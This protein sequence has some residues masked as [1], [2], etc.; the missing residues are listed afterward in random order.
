LIMAR[1]RKSSKAD[2]ILGGLL[3]LA[4]VIG[5]I[6][7][8]VKE[9]SQEIISIAVAIGLIWIVIHFIGRKRKSDT[10]S[11]EYSS[12]AAMPKVQRV[13]SGSPPSRRPS[14]WSQSRLDSDG[15]KEPSI[16]ITALVDPPRSLAAKPGAVLRD[17]RWIRRGETVTI[18]EIT[19]TSGLFY[20]GTNLPTNFYRTEYCLI[21]PGLPIS[22]SS[23]RAAEVGIDSGYTEF[24]PSQRRAF[25][26]WMS[27]GR[28]DPNA[29]PS[30]VSLFLFGL[31]Y[32]LFKQGAVSDAPELIR[33]I[34]RLIEVYGGHSQFA[35]YAN[36]FLPYA[37]ALLPIL[38]R[39]SP[40]FARM[41]Q[42]IPLDVRVF[43]GGKIA[44]GEPITADDALLW[45]LALPTVWLRTPATRCQEEF[46]GLWALRFKARYPGWFPVPRLRANIS[47]TYKAVS[48]TFEAPLHGNFEKLP[49]IASDEDSAHKLKE[50]VN[51][52]TD[53]LDP[54]SRL[55]GRRP[56]MA[57]K[58]QLSLLLPDDLWVE[59]FEPVKSRLAALLG[60]KVARVTTLRNLLSEAQ[61]P[62]DGA[63]SKDLATALKRFSLALRPIDIGLEPDG[64]IADEVQSLETSV[65]L[66]KAAGGAPSPAEGLA[67][68]IARRNAIEIALLGAASA[69]GVSVA[70][71]SAV[72]TSVT[73]GANLDNTETLRLRAYAFAAQPATTRLTKLL[74]GVGELVIEDRQSIARCAIAAVVTEST[75]SPAAV[76]FLERLYKALD[77]SVDDLYPCLHRGAADRIAPTAKADEVMID[78]E[79]LARAREATHA[80]SKILADVF[81]DDAAAIAPP[82]TKEPERSEGSGFQ[83][84]DAPHS[85][86][87]SSLLDNGPLSRQDFEARVKELKLLA[88][89]AIAQIDEW[90]F[91]RFDEPLIEDGGTVM[92]AAHLR[93]RVVEMRGT[94]Q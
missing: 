64:G 53:E 32:R 50:F 30:I 5:F 26:E 91:D 44:K 93:D 87:L 22:K 82:E 54:Y 38:E 43:V 65:C 68:R 94:G 11:A 21:N 33:E 42:E 77:L 80:V 59:R 72:A 1:R 45:A 83:G 8:V 52:C 25:L 27:S 7:N 17:A 28:Q 9:Y 14:A 18:Q 81:T 13:A 70:A 73:A 60:N 92:I 62:L 29:D 31:E 69:G 19:I 15:S 37:G 47:A 90:A 63:P 66:F 56:E 41:G 2:G 46:K 23:G 20:C 6:I 51:A 57:G 55:I 4:V 75:V 35:W 79:R 10:S 74:N 76:N 36:R 39:P 40:R 12:A 58:P 84:L 89:G 85:A 34:E 24:K 61:F 86:L 48:G 78:P 67:E 49:D 16:Q 88:D 71:R 3:V